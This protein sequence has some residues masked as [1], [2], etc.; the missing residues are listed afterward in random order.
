MPEVQA[1]RLLRLHRD[2]ERQQRERGRGVRRLRNEE[3][4]GLEQ[5]VE[6]P[7]RVLDQQLQRRCHV[8]G[9]QRVRK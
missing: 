8:E 6:Q 5:R 2:Q 4:R 1:G 3:H 9:G 7:Q